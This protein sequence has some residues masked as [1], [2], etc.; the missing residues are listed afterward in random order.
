MNLKN[1]KRDCLINIR[2]TKEQRDFIKDLA[3]KNE[4]TLTDFI[5]TLI[6]KYNEDTYE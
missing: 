3:K 6:E 5:L 2:V 4:Q 1:E